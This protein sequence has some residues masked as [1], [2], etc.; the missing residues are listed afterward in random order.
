MSDGRGA[1]G[2]ADD[3]RQQHYPFHV[4]GQYVTMSDCKQG[5]VPQHSDRQA[6]YVLRAEHFASRSILHSL[7]SGF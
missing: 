3:L 1:E 7:C 2:G 6:Y 5:H 4:L